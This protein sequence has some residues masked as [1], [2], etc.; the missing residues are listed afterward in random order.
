MTTSPPSALTVSKVGVS[1]S[2]K[3]GISS[4]MKIKNGSNGTPLALE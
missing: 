4:T 3:A 2:H 1:G